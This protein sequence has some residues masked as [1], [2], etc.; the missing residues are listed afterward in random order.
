MTGRMVEATN[1][2]SQII[3][4]GNKLGAGIYMAEIRRGEEVSLM[5]LIKLE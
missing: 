2:S 4:I 3:R 5:K 1:S